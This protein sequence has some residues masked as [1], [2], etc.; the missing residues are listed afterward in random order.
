LFSLIQ[1]VSRV[2]GALVNKIP[3]EIVE[4]LTG[5]AGSLI[6]LLAKLLEDS[7]NDVK[8]TTLQ[9]VKYVSKQSH[10]VS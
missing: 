3:S 5:G 10:A 9:V 7:A 6:A 4:G 1:V 8:V 2:I